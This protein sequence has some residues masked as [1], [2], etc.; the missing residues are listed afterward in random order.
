MPKWK[1]AALKASIL[2]TR[3]PP[4]ASGFLVK[5]P[6]GKSVDETLSAVMPLLTFVVLQHLN[7]SLTIFLDSTSAQTDL[8]A[9]LF[10]YLFIF[11]SCK[12]RKPHWAQHFRKDTQSAST[13]TALENGNKSGF[14]SVHL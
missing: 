6:P 4:G 13:S 3:K 11:H 1:T 10:I 5:L 14:M 12:S 9:A 7:R 8:V 2:G